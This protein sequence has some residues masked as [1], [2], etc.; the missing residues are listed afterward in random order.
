MVEQSTDRDFP[1]SLL[2]EIYA[3]WP[4]AYKITSSEVLLT[5]ERMRV[6]A[7]PAQKLDWLLQA[8][9]PPLMTQPL[10][11]T[12]DGDALRVATGPSVRMSAT[13]WREMRRAK[14]ACQLDTLVASHES[15]WLVSKGHQSCAGTS[16]PPAR[17]AWHADFPLHLCPPPPT[18]ELPPLDRPRKLSAPETMA[19]NTVPKPTN[20]IAV[21]PAAEASEMNSVP[22]AGCEGLSASLLEKVLRRQAEV[23]MQVEAAPGQHRA[24]LL[25]RLPDLSIA[26]RT[27]MKEARKRLMPQAEVCRRLML[28]AKWLSSGTEL[29]EQ[30]AL[31]AEVAPQWCTIEALGEEKEPHVR[32]DHAVPFGD[33]LQVVKRKVATD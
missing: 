29:C 4:D 13:E 7:T 26:L 11:A 25:R 15:A 18:A 10:A 28:N 3:A 14:M 6:T 12:V 27:C 24:V 21:A 17:Q 2:A 8:A 16:C 31:L 19:A 9:A 32:L 5:E 1:P 23:Q 33:V 20:M 22:V 30:L